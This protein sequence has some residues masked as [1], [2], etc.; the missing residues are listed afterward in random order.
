MGLFGRYFASGGCWQCYSDK[1][2]NRAFL[3]AGS[4]F[5]A[6]R[7]P[8]PAPGDL[9]WEYRKLLNGYSY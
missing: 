9:F 5:W 6:M 1:L 7:T 3:L 2:W 8:G 4:I